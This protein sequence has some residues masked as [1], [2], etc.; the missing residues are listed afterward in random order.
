M[1][2]EQKRPPQPKPPMTIP[3]EEVQL[4]PNPDHAEV[5]A[6]LG[7]SPEEFQAQIGMPFGTLVERLGMDP[8]EL[9]EA[10]RL[11]NWSGAVPVGL[12]QAVQ[13]LRSY[14]LAV[15]QQVAQRK[16]ERNRRMDPRSKLGQLRAAAAKAM[17]AKA[18]QL[19]G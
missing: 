9:A 11:M 4:S 5:A 18:R 15:C 16:L 10:L 6:W 14:G 12:K 7:M 19:R 17:T 8:R 3:G 1:T 2:Q 13:L